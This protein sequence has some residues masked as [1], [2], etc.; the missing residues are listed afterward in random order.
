MSERS[1]NRVDKYVGGRIRVRR[2]T[3]GISQRK[4]AHALDSNQSV[5]ATRRELRW[6]IVNLVQTLSDS[7]R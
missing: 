6:R 2:K 3:L 5:P 4:L 1:P 7:R